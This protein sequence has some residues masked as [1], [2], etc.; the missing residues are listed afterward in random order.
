M[1]VCARVC[2]CVYMYM[3]SSMHACLKKSVK[4][5]RRCWSYSRGAGVTDSVSD[6]AWVLGTRLNPLQGAASVLSC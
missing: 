6:L 2:A 4:A 5:R 3:H 1:S